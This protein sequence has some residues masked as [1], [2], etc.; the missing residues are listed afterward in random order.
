MTSFQHPSPGLACCRGSEDTDC[1]VIGMG[2]G[3]FPDSFI[4]Q[5][6]PGKHCH[7]A[8]LTDKETEAKQGS[9]SC[10][11]T[12][13]VSG[14]ARSWT[15]GPGLSLPSSCLAR[16]HA[17]SSGSSQDS[18]P[19]SHSS[20]SGVTLFSASVSPPAK[21]GQERYFLYGRQRNHE[22]INMQEVP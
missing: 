9:P 18:L 21:R 13:P 15:G 17:V 10:K 19:G 20:S 12:Q 8:H 6:W 22:L 2:H 14:W 5:P 1:Q 16:S 7:Q 4:V 3:P 11:D